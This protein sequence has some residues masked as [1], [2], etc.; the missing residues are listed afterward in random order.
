MSVGSW[1][2]ERNVV[3]DQ[4]T[5]SYNRGEALILKWTCPHRG[6]P[7]KAANKTT[8]KL[9]MTVGARLSANTDQVWIV[10]ADEAQASEGTLQAGLYLGKGCSS[11]R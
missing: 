6:V 10:T 4:K 9:F 1:D 7:H 11:D 3:R 8:H 2:H 5:I